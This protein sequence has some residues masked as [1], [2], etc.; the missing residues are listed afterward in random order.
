MLGLAA[1]YLANKRMVL[2]NAVDIAEREINSN[3]EPDPNLPS[4][5][6]R[7][8]QRRPNVDRYEHMNTQD[9]APQS[10]E[11]LARQ[12]DRLQA[13]AADYER[14]GARQ[15]TGEWFSMDRGEVL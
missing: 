1:G 7:G 2:Q 8:V 9:V 3:T 14:H 10:L 6:I 5:K 11:Q 12:G 13:E 4:Q 15:I